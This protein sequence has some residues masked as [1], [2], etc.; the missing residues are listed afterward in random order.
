MGASHRDAAGRIDG[1]G[2]HLDGVLGT[3]RLPFW[4]PLWHADA[5]RPGALECAG[6]VQPEAVITESFAGRS[7]RRDGCRRQCGAGAESK[8]H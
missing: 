1:G 3:D 4:R 5:W 8:R 7:Q 2:E 6:H